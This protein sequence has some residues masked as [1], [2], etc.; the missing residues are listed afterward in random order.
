MDWL[1]KRYVTTEL[2][3]SSVVILR[4]PIADSS[5]AK[6]NRNG[7]CQEPW[8]SHGWVWVGVIQQ[9][10][11]LPH[12]NPSEIPLHPLQDMR[13][14]T[15]SSHS[16][17]AKARPPG[18]ARHLVSPMPFVNSLSAHHRCQAIHS[19]QQDVTDVPLCRGGCIRR[20]SHHPDLPETNK[21]QGPGPALP[22]TAAASL[23]DWTR[24]SYWQRYRFPVLPTFEQP[25]RS[26][27]SSSLSCDA[28]T[29]ARRGETKPSADG[30][31]SSPEVPYVR[32]VL[33]ISVPC[34]VVP[35]PSSHVLGWPRR[36]PP[37]SPTAGVSGDCRGLSVRR[38]RRGSR[39]I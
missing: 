36:A 4:N 7:R 8:F 28:V 11:P 9:Q 1:N 15:T 31:E 35:L 14:P 37:S 38:S 30:S 39:D 16:T 19:S 10:T 5:S 33:A 13:C 17:T 23:R 18:T 3:D 29:R 25:C 26:H 21:P 27:L 12:P 6:A 34:V 22:L 2:D 24:Q 32:D 20:Q